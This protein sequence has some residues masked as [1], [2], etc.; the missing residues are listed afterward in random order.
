MSKPLSQLVAYTVMKNRAALPP[1]TYS[2]FRGTEWYGNINTH[3]SGSPTVYYRYGRSLDTPVTDTTWAIV[4]SGDLYTH[5]YIARPNIHPIP[6]DMNPDFETSNFNTVFAT[7]FGG[8]WTNLY[9]WLGANAHRIKSLTGH[10]TWRLGDSLNR[11]V[12]YNGHML[13]L[14]SDAQ[15]HEGMKFTNTGIPLEWFVVNLIENNPVRET[16]TALERIRTRIRGAKRFLYPVERGLVCYQITKQYV[17]KLHTSE[18]L[19]H[20]QI[21]AIANAPTLYVANGYAGSYTKC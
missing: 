18:R 5:T 17:G 2:I 16:P 13:D 3:S 1:G 14:E 6:L 8:S 4:S 11:Y 7:A 19:A 9:A 21:E 12:P 15:I 10:G 20:D